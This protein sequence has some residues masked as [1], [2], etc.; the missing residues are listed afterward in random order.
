MLRSSRHADAGYTTRPTDGAYHLVQAGAND[1]S[2][3]NILYPQLGVPLR[4][5]S[6]DL[7][8]CG[9]GRSWVFLRVLGGRSW[10]PGYR[11]GK[12]FRQ[13]F[14]LAVKRP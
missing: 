12:A 4:G 13:G 1:E 11:S 9:G 2:L 3:D 8:G 6:E 7:D 10:E 14:G 5:Y